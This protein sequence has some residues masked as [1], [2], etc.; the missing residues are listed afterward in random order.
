MHR[1]LWAPWRMAY[2]RQLAQESEDVAVG[3]P[4]DANRDDDFLATAWARPDLDGPN[5]VVHRDEAGLILL[6]R[7]PYANGHLL[8]ALGAAAP[9]LLDYGSDGRA[10]FWTLVD[11]AVALCHRALRPQGV[12]IGVNEGRAAGAGVPSHL[13]AHVVPRWGGDTNFI[14]VIGEIRVI[15]ES[16]EVMARQ[17]RIANAELGPAET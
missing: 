17:Y 8:V 13:H 10:A 5:H 2:L 7:Y 9:R 15:P 3:A 4:L 14:S 12:N 11:R 6:N 1:N 16:L